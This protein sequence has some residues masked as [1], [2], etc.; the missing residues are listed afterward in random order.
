MGRR[1]PRSAGTSS[2][3]GRRWALP[4]EESRASCARMSLGMLVAKRRII[5]V[6]G[7]TSAVVADGE[8]DAFFGEGLVEAL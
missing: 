2:S 4:S 5:R 6:F 7:L 8:I 1:A 3:W